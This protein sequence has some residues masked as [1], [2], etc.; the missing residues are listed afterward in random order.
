MIETA[1]SV[2]FA[3]WSDA[4]VGDAVAAADNPRFVR[5]PFNSAY[6]ALIGLTPDVSA[7]AVRQA[8]LRERSVGVVAIN[9]VNALRIAY[10]STRAED[11]PEI[12]S[13]IDE[14]VR[15]L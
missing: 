6:F 15:G 5:F 13:H 7:E 1:R 4:C 11:L 3:E 2:D 12:V 9:S 10:C 14:V 8:L